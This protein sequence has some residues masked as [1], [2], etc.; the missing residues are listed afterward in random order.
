MILNKIKLGNYTLKNRLVVSPMC[1]YSGKNGSP[2]KWH[3]SH[4]LKLLQSGASMLTLESTAINKNGKI[5]HADLCLS[6]N[7]QK[8]DF[9][10]L[11][12][13]LKSFDKNIP[14]CLQVSHSGRK[15]SSHIPWIKSNTPLNKK[16]KKW[17]TFS[18]SSIRK[19]KNWPLPVSLSQKEIKKIIKDFVK[20][21]KL[22]N[23][24]GFDGIEIHMAHGYLL[25]QFLSPI[26]N[27][28]NDEYGGSLKKRCNLAL[29]VAS[30]IR[31]VWPRKKILG[32][33]ITGLDHLPG[34][35]NINESIFLAKNLSSI[36]INYICVSSGGILTKTKLKFFEGFRINIASKIK[37]KINIPVR[38]SGN[39]E[40]LNFADKAIKQKKIDLIAIGRNFIKDPSFIYNFSKKRNYKKIIAKPYLRCI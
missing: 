24:A 17:K 40:N 34:G 11:I 39:L 4:L 9:K 6:N 3:Y 27:K 35:I 8:K 7:K 18:A 14:I 15:G 1:Q 23:E 25:H 21:A 28:R 5:T 36:G 20:T 38:T 26:S 10:N 30:K 16:Q 12:S 29:Q 37:K 13:F 22:A 31:K 19:D 33:R 2:T 32:A